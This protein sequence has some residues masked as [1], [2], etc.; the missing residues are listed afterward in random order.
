MLE[1]WPVAVFGDDSLPVGDQPLHDFGVQRHVPSLV[2]LGSAARL[3]VFFTD[4]QEPF[5]RYDLLRVAIVYEIEIECGAIHD[6][7]HAAAGVRLHQ[8]RQEMSSV[9]ACARFKIRVTCLTE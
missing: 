4:K 2:T 9:S 7:R 1:Q 8:Q 3:P 6:F 5:S